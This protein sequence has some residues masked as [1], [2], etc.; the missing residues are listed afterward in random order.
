MEKERHLHFGRS[1]KDLLDPIRVLV[2]IGIEK[3]D[4]FLDAGC[5][6]GFL[7]LAASRL[8]TRC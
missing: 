8:Y 6:D 3:G 1:A 4:V 7:S 5:G 2:E